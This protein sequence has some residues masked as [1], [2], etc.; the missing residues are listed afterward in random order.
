MRDGEPPVPVQCG[1]T[2]PHLGRWCRR[3]RPSPLEALGM[4]EEGRIE[5]V[6]ALL[7]DQLHLTLVHLPGGEEADATVAM[8]KKERRKLSPCCSEPKR[9]GNSGRTRSAPMKYA[10]PPGGRSRQPSVGLAIIVGNG[11]IVPCDTCGAGRR[12][13]AGADRGA[14][15]PQ[16]GEWQAGTNPEAPATTRTH[17]PPAANKAAPVMDIINTVLE[18]ASG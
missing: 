1:R 3:Q 12:A 14:A 17:Q 16:A 6:P 18:Q 4:C 7:G 10:F 9:S 8:E 11:N 13:R 2:D 15:W 5:G